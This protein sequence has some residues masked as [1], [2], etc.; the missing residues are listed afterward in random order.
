MAEIVNLNQFRKQRARNA[1]ELRAGENRRK[2]GRTK[3]EKSSLQ[4][5]REKTEKELDDKRLE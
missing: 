2:F 3:E 5:E 1:A 4:R